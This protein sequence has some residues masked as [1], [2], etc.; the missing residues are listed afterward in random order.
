[1]HVLG[2]AEARP[3]IVYCGTRKDTDEVA[4]EICAREGSRR[5]PTTRA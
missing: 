5:S 2:D 3:A 4:G 1:M